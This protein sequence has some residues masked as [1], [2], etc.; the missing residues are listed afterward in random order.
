M[1]FLLKTLLAAGGPREMLTARPWPM[2]QTLVE[3]QGIAHT[4]PSLVL[5]EIW[6]SPDAG[7]GY[8]VAGADTALLEL[9]SAGV[10]TVDGSGPQACYAAQDEQLV[11][12]RRRLLRLPASDVELLYRTGSRWATLAARSSKNF[13][14]PAMSAESTVTSEKPLKRRRRAVPGAS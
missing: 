1:S 6:I 4:A 3:L 11:D 2:H 9:R 5:P 13:S 14:I 12:A 7:V 8:R 10:V